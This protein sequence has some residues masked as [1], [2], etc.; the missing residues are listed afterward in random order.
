MGGALQRVPELLPDRIAILV[1][2]RLECLGQLLPVRSVRDVLF[3][4]IERRRS[5]LVAPD[6]FQLGVRFV[7]YTLAF[8]PLAI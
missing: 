3:A 8:L 7:V 6:L 2:I 4:Q 1:Q 5:R